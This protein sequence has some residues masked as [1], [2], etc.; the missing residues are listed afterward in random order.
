MRK[1]RREARRRGGKGQKWLR[2]GSAKTNSGSTVARLGPRATSL[3]DIVA[4][5]GPSGR[6]GG[7][8]VTALDDPWDPDDHELG[9]C[10]APIRDVLKAARKWLGQREAQL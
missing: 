6:Q 7:W 1:G 4:Y 8:R 10:D 5:V 3:P 9:L 2:T